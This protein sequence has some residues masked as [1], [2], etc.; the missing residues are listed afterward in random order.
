[1][2]LQLRPNDMLSVNVQLYDIKRVWRPS[3]PRIGGFSFQSC[4]GGRFVFYLS[5]NQYNSLWPSDLE[6]N[7]NHVLEINLRET[8][9]IFA[10]LFWVSPDVEHFVSKANQF[11]LHMSCFHVQPV[12]NAGMWVTS[13]LRP[14]GW[15]HIW[16]VS[17]LGC[18]GAHPR[19]SI[20]ASH[21][22]AL[23][24]SPL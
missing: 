15:G 11:V 23:W 18:S 20:V 14:L 2:C 10:R 8:S 7:I 6:P 4:V 19:R 17:L 22:S 5:A 24:Q 12:I 3:P 13:L 9:R 21:T 1:M 16:R